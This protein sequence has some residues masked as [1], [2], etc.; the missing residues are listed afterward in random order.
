MGRTVVR[1]SMYFSTILNE[2]VLETD[3][4]DVGTR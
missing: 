3:A 2:A 4:F 1:R